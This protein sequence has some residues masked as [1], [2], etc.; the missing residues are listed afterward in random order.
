MSMYDYVVYPDLHTE[1][2]KAWDCVGNLYKIGHEV[3]KLHNQESFCIIMRDR[4]VIRVENCK[5]MEITNIMPNGDTPMFDKWGFDFDPV[6]TTG[7]LDTE[8]YF[9]PSVGGI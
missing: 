6:N 7:L 2:I 3:P 9:Y 8:P 5:L 4:S 1:Q